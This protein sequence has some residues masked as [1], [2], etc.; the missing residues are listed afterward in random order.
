MDILDLQLQKVLKENRKDFIGSLKLTGIDVEQG[1]WASD[2]LDHNAHVGAIS[3]VLFVSQENIPSQCGNRFLHTIAENLDD[4]HSFSVMAWIYA[5][6]VRAN[7]F[8]PYAIIQHMVD[9]ALFRE[10][11]VF[12]QRWLQRY[13]RGDLS[14]EQTSPSLF[15]C[16]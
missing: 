7:Q 12:L 1:V 6:Y 16:P 11:C 4:E 15:F 14:D 8:P 10:Y 13:L 3:L 5:A 9:P 2:T